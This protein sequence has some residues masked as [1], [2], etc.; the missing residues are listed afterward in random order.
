MAFYYNSLSKQ[1]QSANVNKFK[2]NSNSSTYCHVSVSYR[3][4]LGVYLGTQL[5]IP[6]KKL[7]Y[8]RAHT[9]NPSSREAEHCEFQTRLVD[10]V[11]S[12][13]A[14]VIESEPFSKQI[15]ICIPFDS[16]I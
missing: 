2:L 15:D 3:L 14:R 4:L 10:I 7:I 11:I 5:G 9:L 8:S 12:R 6:I 16:T 1:S 13:P